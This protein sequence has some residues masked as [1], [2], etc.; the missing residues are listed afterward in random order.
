LAV[1]ERV[2]WAP[3]SFEEFFADQ[4][5]PRS[6]GA[7]RPVLSLWDWLSWHDADFRLRRG[8]NP[9]VRAVDSTL[10]AL[11]FGKGKPCG[12]KWAIGFRTEL[13]EWLSS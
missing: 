4:N 8:V 13:R 6:K 1:G 11:G 7:L 2:N 9:T 12:R 3:F 5:S 10:E